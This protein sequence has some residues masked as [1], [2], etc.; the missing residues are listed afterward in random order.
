MNKQ[1]DIKKLKKF[2]KKV[3]LIDCYITKNINKIIDIK[4]D[5]E[6]IK[7]NNYVLGI[8]NKLGKNSLNILLENSQFKILKELIEYDVRILRFKNRN[9]KNFLM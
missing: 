2:N 5:F 9:E 8:T 7:N 6:F 4:E 1:K 3:S